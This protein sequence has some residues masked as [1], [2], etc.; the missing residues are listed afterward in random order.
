MKA[1]GIN[2]TLSA[3]F[4]CA[5]APSAAHLATDW[6]GEAFTLKIT[7]SEISGH[8]CGQHQMLTLIAYDITDPKRLHHAAKICEDWGMRVQYSMF[9]CRLEATA[10]DRFWTALRDEI[11][12]KTDR[13]VAYKICAN[14][15]RD[16]RS[17]GT[18]VHNEKVVAYVC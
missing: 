18:M 5:P 14:C 12:P 3:N 9:E 10:F 17:A 13:I 7:P 8:R 6:W 4:S 11:D 15:A 2:S 16:T 1:N